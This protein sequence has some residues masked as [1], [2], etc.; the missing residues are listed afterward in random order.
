MKQFWFDLTENRFLFSRFRFDWKSLFWWMIWFDWKSFFKRFLNT[1][2]P[3][4]P[5]WMPTL[6]VCVSVCLYP[7]YCQMSRR[8]KLKMLGHEETISASACSWNELDPITHWDTYARNREK[9]EAKTEKKVNKS[10][11]VLKRSELKHPCSNSWCLTWITNYPYSSLSFMNAQSAISE[12]KIRFWPNYNV[13]FIAD[14][15]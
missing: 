8:I 2:S 14:T 4:S 6:S 3:P 5:L 7:N 9:K 12:E 15:V 10:I 13:Q 11:A 1:L